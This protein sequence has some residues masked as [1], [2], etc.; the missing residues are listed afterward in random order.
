MLGLQLRD[1]HK[2]RRLKGTAIELTNNNNNYT[3]ATQ[4]L[5]ADFLRIT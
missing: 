4:I 2:G 5:A 3:G 1:E